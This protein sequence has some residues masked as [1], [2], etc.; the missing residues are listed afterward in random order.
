MDDSIIEKIEYDQANT[1]LIPINKD[2]IYL[3]NY[4]NSVTGFNV[5]TDFPEKDTID[6]MFL[7]C[8]KTEF[9]RKA[10]NLN[11]FNSLQF[12]WVDFGINHI[13][14]GSDAYFENCIT[15]LS[16]KQYESVRIGS[17]IDPRIQTLNVDIYRQIAWYFAGGVFGG[18]IEKLMEFADL[19]KDKCIETIH[20]KGTLM[21]E[22]NIWYLVFMENTELFNLYSCD[23]NNTLIKNY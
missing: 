14:N 22:V 15:E 11:P 12:I 21:W 13:F 6:Y 1:L 8:S 10:L 18:N 3:Y 2:D 16:K 19:V 7:M 5:D 17:I 4:R 9:I 20:N 23:H